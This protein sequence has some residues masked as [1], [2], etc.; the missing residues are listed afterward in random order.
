MSLRRWSTTLERRQLL[1]SINRLLEE[2]STLVDQMLQS[3]SSSSSS[4]MASSTNSR[5]SSITSS[6]SSSPS[7]SSSLSSSTD[8]DSSDADSTE[9][10]E[11]AL[12]R[13]TMEVETQVSVVFSPFQDHSVHWGRGPVISDLSQSDCIENCRMRKEH[14]STVCEKLWPRMRH[15]FE[16]NKSSIKCENRYTTHFET[17]MIVLLYRMSRPWR[18]RPDMEQSLYMRKSKLS[19]IVHTF[20]AAL[21]KFATPFLNGALL[22]HHRMPY[23]AQLIEQKTNGLMDCVWGFI[24]GTIRKTARPIYHQR[25]V[26]TRFKKCHGVK[27]QSVTVPDGFIAYLRGPWPAQTHDARML[28]ESQ[29]MEELADIMPANGASE[30]YALYGDLAYAQSIYLLGG[31][32]KPPVGSDEAL[33][34]RQ[35]SSVRITVEWGSGDIVDK[36]KFL[37]FR[38]AMKIF[39]MPVGEFY[40]NGTFLSNICNCLYGN[41]TQQYFGAVQLSSIW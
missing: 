21:Y 22:W 31:F 32:R 40:T 35:M 9:D 18:L 6:S 3:S 26:Y 15:L 29:L 25:S 23:Y 14:L 7:S 34:N 33:F 17:G 28:R 37:D 19:S 36:W 27:F 4:E 39:E 38:S 24:D 16:G 11:V 5:N 1:T 13:L 2:E 20:S 10:P 8:E 41:K 30:V 12:V